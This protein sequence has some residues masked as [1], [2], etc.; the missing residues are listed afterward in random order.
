MTRLL[1]P[2]TRANVVWFDDLDSTAAFADRLVNAWLSAD[3]EPLAETLL[4]AERQFAGRGRGGHVWESPDGGL[5]AN[6]L[7]WLPA[8]ALSAVPMAVGVTLASI[9]EAACPEA[10]VGLKWPNDLLVTGRKLG[11][12]LCQSRGPGDPMWV[13]VGFGIN[14]T[15][16]PV[17][18]A[19]DDVQAVSLRDLGW[20][21]DTREGS[22][23]LAEAF[24][25]GIHGALDDPETTRTQ[26]AR[27][28]VHR[29]G[30]RILLRLREANVEGR[31]AGFDQDGLL[32]LDVAGQVRRFSA[33]EILFTGEPGGE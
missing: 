9:V 15:A 26:W 29:I 31:F 32:E 21:G 23:A 18:A 1:F 30:D 4:V 33:G 22:W 5:Y 10:R 2:G 17:L 25:A 13:S 7:A 8:A 27:R 11:G 6:W 19:G 28:T 14:L 12:I 20:A 3:E 16:T 24:L